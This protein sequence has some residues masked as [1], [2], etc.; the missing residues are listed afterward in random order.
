[1]KEKC[2]N[3]FI[4]HSYD[5]HT[6]LIMEYTRRICHSI[7]NYE[8]SSS[9]IYQINLSVCLFVCATLEILLLKGSNQQI[10]VQFETDQLEDSILDQLYQL[11]SA[12][13]V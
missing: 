2:Q 11:K 9:T 3:I 6:S 4:L 8:K 5:I 13:L 1:M 10:R 7:F 12:V